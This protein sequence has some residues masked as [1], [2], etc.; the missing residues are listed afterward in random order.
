MMMYTSI[1]HADLVHDV[2]DKDRQ[3]QNG[4]DHDRVFATFKSRFVTD[5]AINRL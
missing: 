4:G 3:V 1:A 2:T 5:Y